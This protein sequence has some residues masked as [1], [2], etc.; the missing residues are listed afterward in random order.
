M[1]LHQPGFVC[2]V[3]YPNGSLVRGEFFS[4]VHDGR[5]YLHMVT[6]N[7]GVPQSGSLSVP[8]WPMLRFLTVDGE[9]CEFT[10]PMIE[11][12]L[13]GFDKGA[14]LSG[15]RIEPLQWSIVERA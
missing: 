2:L 3:G 12:R 9:A 13:V 8:I 15:I 5:R 11:G 1:A 4:I 7:K 6:A 14:T 10:Q